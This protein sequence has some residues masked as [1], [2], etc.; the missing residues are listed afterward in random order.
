M[1]RIEK[2]LLGSFKLRYE[3]EYDTI[4]IGSG[5]SGLALASIL[6]KDG[7]KVLVLERHYVAGG[8]THTFKRGNYVWDVGLHYVGEVGTN[9]ELKMIYD[10][11]CDTPIEWEDMGEVYDKVYFGNEVFEFRKGTEAFV[12]YFS[13]IFPNEKKNLERYVLILEEVARSAKMYYAEKAVPEVVGKIIGKWMRNAYMKY[14]SRTTQD[15]L[16]ELFTD[17][18]LK[19]ILAAQFGDYGLIPSKSSFVMHATV[20]HH[21]MEGGFYPVGGSRVIYEKIAPVIR[22]S[23]GE[24]FVNA[25]VEEILVE[26]GKATGV[27]LASGKIWKADTIISTV[28]PEK[29]YTKFLSKD[30]QDKYELKEKIAGMNPSLSYVGL[31]I[32]I[33]ESS[34]QL[35]LPKTNFWIFPDEYDHDKNFADHENG[36]SKDLPVVYISF[37]SAKDPDFNERHPGISTIEII[38]IV[39]MNAFEKWGDT[40]WK[41]R[42][43]VYDELKKKISEQ[44][45]EYLYKYVPQTKGKVDYYE[46]STPLTIQHFQGYLNG[47]MYGIEFTPERFKNRSLKPRTP[48]KNL[49]LAGQDIVCAG[50]GGAVMSAIVCVS[51]IKNTNYVSKIVK[52][53]KRA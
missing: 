19:A 21:Y 34:E 31:Y 51:A 45:L 39:D 17:K 32:G 33:K 41:H 27:K 50:I 42:G 43:A 36:N 48:V 2:P 26:N 3:E 53:A 5:M 40:E 37:P 24:I 7:Q 10:Y 13:E 49:F 9:T 4:I 52:K 6:S 14:A 16:N 12:K 11:I 20:A 29:T 46:L 23:G 38:T 8:C 35:N 44:L 28:G 30:I 22:R 15:V 47:E 25:E 1:N 18:K